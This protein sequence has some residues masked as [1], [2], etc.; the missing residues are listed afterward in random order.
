MQPA[1]DSRQP[2]EIDLALARARSLVV[3]LVLQIAP[4]LDAASIDY[5]DSLHEVGDIDS[6]DFLRLVALTA[7]ATG[8]VVPPRD[9]GCLATLDGFAR[10]L[11]ARAPSD[12][13]ACA[14]T[15]G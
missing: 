14:A 9:Y 5:S 1:P 2:D 10:Y 12:R 13:L 8:I 3:R 11:A 15:G 4:E 6:L 7:E